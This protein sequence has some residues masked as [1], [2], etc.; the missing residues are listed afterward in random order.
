MR[1]LGRPEV[2][3][4]AIPAGLCSVLFWAGH[5]FATGW[6]QW[7]GP[8]RAAVWTESGIVEKLRNTGL[9]IN[10]NQ[11]GAAFPYGGF[12][13]RLYVQPAAS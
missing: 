9:G 12:K 10:R 5:L 4:S 6:P 3:R 7:R 2:L 1:S 11:S 8:N 13:K